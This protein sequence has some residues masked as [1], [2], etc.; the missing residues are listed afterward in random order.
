MLHELE[1]M[2]NDLL[3]HYHGIELNRFALCP[4]CL[5]KGIDA[6]GNSFD[7]SANSIGFVTIPGTSGQTSGTL[8]LFY[9]SAPL[10]Y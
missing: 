1:T 3:S 10:A 7:L 8:W 9:C 5:V 2:V 4:H 6:S